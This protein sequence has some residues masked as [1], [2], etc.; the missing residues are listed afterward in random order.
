MKSLSIKQI[1]ITIVLSYLIIS[2]VNA[3]MNPFNLAVY[4]RTM[5]VFIIGISLAIQLAIKNTL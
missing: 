5:Q 1:L 2:F 3:E 4:V